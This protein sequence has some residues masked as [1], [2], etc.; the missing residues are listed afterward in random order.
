MNKEGGL[1][2]S[3]STMDRMSSGEELPFSN[4]VVSELQGDSVLGRI[5]TATGN[6]TTRLKSVGDMFETEDDLLLFMMMEEF[7]RC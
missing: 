3:I 7:E 6:S 5:H 2:R 4:H 1:R